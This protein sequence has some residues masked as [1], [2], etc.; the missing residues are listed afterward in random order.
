MRSALRRLAFR[1]ALTALVAAAPGT[2]WAADADDAPCRPD[3]PWLEIAGGF[4][5]DGGVGGTGRDVRPHEGVGGTGRDA[6]PHEGVG[7]TGRDVRPHEGVGGTGRDVRPHEGVGG[8]GIYGTITGF[9]S[10][11]VNGERVHYDDDVPV[12]HGEQAR[13]ADD[14]AVGQRVWVIAS[15]VDGELRADSIV[16]VAAAR[17]RV[18]EVDPAIGRV[19]VD[20]RWVWWTDETTVADAAGR[21]LERSA[22]VGADVTVFGLEDAAGDLLA[23]RIE[24]HDAPAVP[25]QPVRLEDRLADRDD[26]D[27]LSVE[28]VVLERADGRLRVGPV[29][30]ALPE[31]GLE[32]EEGERVWLRGALTRERVLRPERIQVRPARPDRVRPEVAQ[33]PPRDVA[34]APVRAERTRGTRPER[35]ERFSAAARPTR[36]ERPERPE[37]AAARIA[38]PTAPERIDRPSRPDMRPAR[39]AHQ[40]AAARRARAAR[41]AARRAARRDARR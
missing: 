18:G 30:V 34:P 14:L 20:G 33:R 8:T 10:I 15:E 41:Q 32:V 24:V 6:R 26:L 28:G 31:G 11:C 39:D 4:S 17:G 13:T 29:W 22:L 16:L 1:L 23:T 7:G 38:R 36:L 25:L 19:Q 2:V 5:P 40:L 3:T 9:G 35:P 21:P 37:T 27:T 12:A